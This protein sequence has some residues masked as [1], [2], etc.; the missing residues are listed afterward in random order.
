MSQEMHHLY[1]RDYTFERLEATRVV[2][3][4]DDD[5]TIHLVANVWRRLKNDR[6][7]VADSAERP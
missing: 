7:E 4:A 2:H 1:D 5:G 3:D 6:H